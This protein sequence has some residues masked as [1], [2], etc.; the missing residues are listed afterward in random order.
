MELSLNTAAGFHGIEERCCCLSV[1][2]GI[3]GPM[4][5]RDGCP[6]PES[7]GKAL[8]FVTGRDRHPAGHSVEKH[9]PPQVANAST[10]I[11]VT[12]PSMAGYGWLM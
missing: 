11:T 3:E 7:R 2:L 4:L 10:P 6:A 9:T 5:W 12:T 8:R 1:G